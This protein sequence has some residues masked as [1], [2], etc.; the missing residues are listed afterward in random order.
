[1]IA[2][3]L[4]ARGGR[5]ISNQTSFLRPITGG[6]DPRHRPPPPQRPHDRG[7]G[8]RH[9]RRRGPP[10]RARADDGLPCRVPDPARRRRT[11]AA[12]GRP[13]LIAFSRRRQASACTPPTPGRWARITACPAAAS[14]GSKAPETSLC[15]VTS[16]AGGARRRRRSRR[17][18]AAAPPAAGRRTARCWSRVDGRG[19]VRAAR[20]RLV[21]RR[22]GRRRRVGAEALRA[23][24][25]LE[26]ARARTRPA[27]LRSSRATRAA[28]ISAT[29]AAAATTAMRRARSARASR[30]R[31]RA[32]LGAPRLTRLRPADRGQLADRARRGRPPARRGPPARRSRPAARR[33]RRPS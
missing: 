31:R 1:M 2:D 16:A 17:C 11:R 28:M 4:T 7:V 10:V 20:R 9:H 30:A 29:H 27:D 22:G 3:A 13:G 8:G 5:A 14:D 25:G 21:G 18:R 23:A 33:T 19:A 6:H 32:P 15:S 12:A 26:R 24:V